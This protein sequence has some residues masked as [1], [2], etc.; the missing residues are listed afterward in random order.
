MFQGHAGTGLCFL[1]G[2][3][4]GSP[5]MFVGAVIGAIF[6]PLVAYLA[7]FDRA[8]IEQGIYG[9]NS[10]LVGVATFAFLKPEFA[11]TWMLLFAGVAVAVLLTYLGSRFLKFPVYTAPFVV[12]TW[13]IL[14]IAPA[15]S[16]EEIRVPPPPVSSAASGFLDAVLRGESE[17][18]LEANDASGI[19]ILVGIALSNPWHAAMALLGDVVGT[20]LAMYH[21]DPEQSISIG[22]Y[23]YNAAL[24]A[25]ALFLRRNSLT[26][27]FLAA[28]VATPLTEFFPK[29]LG[30]PAL[31][32]PF[33]MASWVVLLAVWSEERLFP[34]NS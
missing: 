19:L 29:W 26:L 25:M 30:V 32:A 20:S 28:L 10:I 16:G 7:S 6:G 17:V 18:M 23:G 13:A 8:K 5:L 1:I 24:A 11:T 22:I 27:P 33:V 21:G 2:I 34:R 14:L 4:L 9:F 15:I 3:A 12:T 31:T